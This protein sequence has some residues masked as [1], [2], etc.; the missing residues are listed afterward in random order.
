MALFYLFLYF[1]ILGEWAC[2]N[3]HIIHESVHKNLVFANNVHFYASF[4]SLHLFYYFVTSHT[5]RSFVADAFFFL[6]PLEPIAEE[7]LSWEGPSGER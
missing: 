1:V 3:D 4:L 2:K 6:N 7:G 5:D